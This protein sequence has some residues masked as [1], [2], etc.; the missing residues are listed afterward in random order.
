MHDMNY[1]WD[2]IKK[3]KTKKK[4]AGDSDVCAQE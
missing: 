3:N 4:Q 1:G 2:S